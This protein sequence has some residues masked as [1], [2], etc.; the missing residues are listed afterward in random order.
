[1]SKLIQI[2]QP[3]LPDSG[4][5]FQLSSAHHSTSLVMRLE[6]R[7]SGAYLFLLVI[8]LAAWSLHSLTRLPLAALL[9]GLVLLA[10]RVP[11]LILRPGLLVT[12]LTTVMSYTFFQFIYFAGQI[13]THVSIYPFLAV[14][15]IGMTL[16]LLIALQWYSWRSRQFDWLLFSLG[17]LMIFSGISWQALNLKSVY[18]ALALL[19]VCFLSFSRLFP[20]FKPHHA[21]PYKGDWRLLRSYYLR[22]AL[23]LVVMGSLALAGIRGMELVDQHFSD[24]L[25]RFL[26]GN[27]RDWSGFSGHTHLQGNKEIELSDNIAFTVKMPRPVDYWRGNIL[28]TYRDGHWFPQE[29]LHLPVAAPKGP[30]AA[31][32]RYLVGAENIEPFVKDLTKQLT[33][34]SESQLVDVQVQNPYQGILFAP[35][36]TR[37]VEIPAQASLYQNQYLLYRRELRERQHHYRLLIQSEEMLP[38]RWDPNILHENLEVQ[39]QIR[40]QLVGLA[41]QITFGSRTSAEKA[42]ALENWFHQHFSYSLRV[43]EMPSGI[44]PTVYFIQQRTPA[45]CSWFAS[46]MVLMLRSLNIPAHVVSGWRSM[47]YNPLARVWVVKE[48]EAHDWVEILDTQ[49]GQW[50]RFD[51]TPPGQLA[52]LTGSGQSAWWQQLGD[53]LSILS[54]N[55]QQQLSQMSLQQRFDWLRNQ[56]LKLLGTPVFYLV[57]VGFLGVNQLLKHRKQTKWSLST[58]DTL[59]YSESPLELKAVI[60]ELDKWLKLRMLERPTEQSLDSWF[61]TIKAQLTVSESEALGQ[62]LELVQAWRFGPDP[63]QVAPLL[64]E[65]L[66]CLPQKASPESADT[67]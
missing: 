43:G 66:A 42:K 53:G 50:L 58:V 52:Q 63:E 13:T 45:Y 20:G 4:P 29:A 67:I 30:D 41:R 25:T 23:V 55:L 62:C 35:A 26:M 38:A 47:D 56:A 21:R 27:E 28:T 6:H 19:F 11:K 33:D 14:E 34:S 10:Y 24:M 49:S 9:L 15:S 2:A 54:Q 39:P 12:V 61:E 44:D 59:N 5:E 57:L 64:A 1:M 7:P 17:M 51:P 3:T 32:D 36:G 31:W 60:S 8:S 18:L 16:L 48:K 46:G 22:I 37:Q 40:K 65:C